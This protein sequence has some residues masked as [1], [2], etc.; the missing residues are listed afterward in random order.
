MNSLVQDPPPT[1]GVERER[2]NQSFL[3]WEVWNLTC[4]TADFQLSFVA[5]G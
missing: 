1:W 5:P 2:K 4:L 3:A